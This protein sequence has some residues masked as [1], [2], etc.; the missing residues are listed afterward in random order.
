MKCGI[1]ET[2]EIALKAAETGHAVLST[3]HTAD[4]EGTISRLVG[5]FDLSQHEAVRLRLADSIIAVVS[6]RLLPRKDGDGRI[7]T[8]EVMRMTTAIRERIVSGDHRGFSEFI[9][10]GWNPY[11]MQTFDQHMIKMI[12]KGLITE[13]TGIAAA[14]S[15]TNF[16]RALKYD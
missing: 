11:Q 14:S 2:I 13:E 5:A 15:P 10:K 9:E 8:V 4:A 16:K 7:A 6:Q 3:V 12:Q 1:Q